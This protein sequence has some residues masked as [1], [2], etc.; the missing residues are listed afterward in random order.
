MG[1]PRWI[2]LFWEIIGY[3][4]THSYEYQYIFWWPGRAGNG[5][6]TVIRVLSKLLG[7]V[8]TKPDFNMR[9]LSDRFYK[10][11]LVNKR[12]AI[13]GDM[14][15]ELVNIHVLKQL[16]GAD[17]QS[18][19]TKFGDERN[20]EPT[21]KLLFAMNKYPSIP[22]GEPLAPI[23]RRIVLLPFDYT[24]TDQNPDIEKQFEAELPGI[25]NQALMG[26][27]RL[28]QNKG[29]FSRCKR[30]E[31]AL[32]RWAGSLNSFRVFIQ[33]MCVVEPHN[34]KDGMFLFELYYHYKEYMEV[35]ASPNWIHLPDSIKTTQQLGQELSEQLHLKSEAHYYNSSVQQ[36]TFMHG[37]RS[38]RGRYPKYFGIR[39]KNEED[40]KKENNSPQTA[41]KQESDS[42][43][44][45]FS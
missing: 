3:C 24:I 38:V 18:T 9:R 28:R 27:Q 12:C 4:L 40:W 36:Q 37:G 16:S 22:T 33:D 32:R 8:F 2:D 25:F 43:E 17:T 6:G 29:Q 20:F 23:L 10:G 30:G 31:Y 41:P 19:H 5:K 13:C 1:D 21:A 42:T 39:L 45:L 26:L 34:E 11:N 7:S 44:S 14:P 15:A 35:H